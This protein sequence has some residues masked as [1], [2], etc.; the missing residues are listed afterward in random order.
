M[1]KWFGSKVSCAK[2]VL[3]L[4]SVSL[5]IQPEP[6][7]QLAM[8]HLRMDALHQPVDEC[9]FQCPFRPWCERACST[10]TAAVPTGGYGAL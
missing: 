10:A 7:T 1:G 6:M 4:E 5:W 2:A 3:L 8:A 9:R